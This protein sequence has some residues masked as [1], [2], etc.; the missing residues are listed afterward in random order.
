MI[1]AT[2]VPATAARV[3]PVTVALVTVA[4]VTVA[5]ATLVAAIAEVGSAAAIVAPAPEVVTADPAPPREPPMVA[6]R[7]VAGGVERLDG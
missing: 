7:A 1:R 3:V 5:V 4:L 2:V 6:G